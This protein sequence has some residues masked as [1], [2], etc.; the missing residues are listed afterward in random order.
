MLDLHVAYQ[1]T[2][3]L[4]E[5]LTQWDAQVAAEGRIVGSRWTDIALWSAARSATVAGSTG[6]EG[7]P[8][9]SAQVGEVLSGGHV[10]AAATDVRE[11]LNYNAA[12]D[13]A[14]R[15]AL[16]PDF[17]WSQELLRRLNAAVMDGL[18]DDGRGE[19]RQQPVTVG[20]MYWPPEHPRL[21]AL[22]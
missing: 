1:V 3:H 16:R 4:G 19:Y 9:S 10:E 11:V 8:L 20:G 22:M 5:L 7:N 6:I 17:E 18:D 12:L 2:P 14:N 15:A 13:L 21:P